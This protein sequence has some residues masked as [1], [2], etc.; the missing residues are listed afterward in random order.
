MDSNS[1]LLII[2]L[3]LILWPCICIAIVSCWNC[4]EGR[5]TCDCCTGDGISEDSMLENSEEHYVRVN[6]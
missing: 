2:L 4:C 3:S 5:W 1:I 6:L